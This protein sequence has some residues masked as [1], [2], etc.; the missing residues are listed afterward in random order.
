MHLFPS[1]LFGSRSLLTQF[2]D[3]VLPQRCWYSCVDSSVTT[4]Q[5]TQ[6]LNIEDRT[7][8]SHLRRPNSV[9]MQTTRFL[10]ETNGSYITTSHIITIPL[11][12]MDHTRHEVTLDIDWGILWW[13]TR[14]DHSGYPGTS[15]SC[16]DVAGNSRMA[17]LSDDVHQLHQERWGSWRGNW[18]LWSNFVSLPAQK[19]LRWNISVPYASSVR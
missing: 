13:N 18:K 11:V 9:Q 3:E 6:M 7:G 16:L 1:F 2:S 5:W 8:P 12:V 14:P 19:G 10:S 17:M 15:T 4:S